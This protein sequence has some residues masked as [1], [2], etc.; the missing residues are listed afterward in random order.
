MGLRGGGG[1]PLTD[2][3]VRPLIHSL[4]PCYS[5]AQI[6]IHYTPHTVEKL[7]TNFT[8]LLL[9]SIVGKYSAQLASMIDWLALR[10]TYSLRENHARL[11]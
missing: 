5:H 11:R 6:S 10:N 4:H 9:Q 7:V 3:P 2:K 8:I 1:T